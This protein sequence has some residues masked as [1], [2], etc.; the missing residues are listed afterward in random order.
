[1]TSD[2]PKH[3]DFAASRRSGQANI[4]FTLIEL[5]VVV[6]I[7]SILAAL[8]LPAL[9]QARESVKSV[10]CMNN[11]KQLYTG[12]ALYAEDN[13]GGVPPYLDYF[14]YLSKRYLGSSETYAGANGV[15]PQ[16]GPTRYPLLKC[17]GEKGAVCTADP[18]GLPSKMYDHPWDP[19]SYMMNF[20]IN[21]G[22]FGY[23]SNAPSKFGENTMDFTGNLAWSTT[24]RVYNASEVVFMMDCKVWYW[25]WL[26]PDFDWL[27]DYPLDDIYSYVYRH[28]GKRANVLYFDGHVSAVQHFSQTG[29]RLYTWKYP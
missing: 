7:V 3:Q 12:F 26:S 24:F 1:M 19:T 14:Y 5:L 29:K 11:L 9:K 13:D 21:H 10:A 25:A 6:A 8:L 4:A 27:V 23:G 22:N 18:S 20:N 16:R 28:P 17:P 2:Q 15:A